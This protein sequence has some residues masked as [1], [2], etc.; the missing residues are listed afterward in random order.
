M[1]PL[2]IHFLTRLLMPV[3]RPSTSSSNQLAALTGGFEPGVTQALP[4]IYINNRKKY[5]HAGVGIASQLPYL[6][7]TSMLLFSI[8]RMVA[9][10]KPVGTHAKA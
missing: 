3:T 7:A 1:R 8:D 2:L 6:S 10:G 9:L 5:E 4:L